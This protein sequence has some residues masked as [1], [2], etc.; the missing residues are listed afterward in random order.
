M[1][2]LI[3]DDE[4]L[5]RERIRRLLTGRP[6]IL[7]HLAAD[8]EEAIRAIRAAPP[9]L[10]FLDVQMPHLDGFEVVERV[11]VNA[12]PLTVFVTAFDEYALRAFEA[13][14]LDYLLKPF[15]DDR[16]EAVL[17]RAERRIREQQ[18]SHLGEAYTRLVETHRGG[19]TPRLSGTGP[20]ERFP[21]RRGGRVLLVRAEEIDWV[22]ADGPYA[23][24]HVG[25][26]RHAVRIAMRELDDR[27]DSQ[28]FIRIHRSTIVNLDRVRELRDMGRGEYEAVLHDGT[29]LKLSRSRRA[30]LEQRLGLSL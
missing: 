20:L 24:L 29:A 18:A 3:V 15:G 28:R 10:V 22:E 26:Q 1:T 5:G 13:H 17:A 2:V 9:D 27:L 7:V 25:R 6:G 16:F 8:G 30:H 21:V 4:H 19:Y 23:L 14:A 11:G 12:M